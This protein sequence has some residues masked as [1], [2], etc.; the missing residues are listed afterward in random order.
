MKK[1]AFLIWPALCGVLISVLIIQFN[2][3]SLAPKTVQVSRVDLTTLTPR[4]KTVVSDINYVQSYAD[5]VEKAAPAVVNIYIRTHDDSQDSENQPLPSPSSEFNSSLGSGVILNQQG[6]IV[7][8][9]HVIAKAD[10]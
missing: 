7:T 5:A 2:Q 1:F 3:Y 4:S 6:Y 9:N 10:G 8:N